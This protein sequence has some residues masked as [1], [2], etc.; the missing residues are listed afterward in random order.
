MPNGRP[1]ALLSGNNQLTIR[2]DIGS[3]DNR[4]QMSFLDREGW[5]G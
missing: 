1:E 4:L 3:G 2:P 5:G